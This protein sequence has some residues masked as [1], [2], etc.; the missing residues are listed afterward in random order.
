MSVQVLLHGPE[1]GLAFDDACAASFQSVVELTHRAGRDSKGRVID[2][3]IAAWCG[4]AGCGSR[5]GEKRAIWSFG[6]P[7][8]FIISPAMSAT[9]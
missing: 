8:L 5:M 6:T 7:W 9:V 4:V 1:G 2:L 3:M